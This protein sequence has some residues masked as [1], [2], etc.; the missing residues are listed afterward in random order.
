MAACD[1]SEEVPEG[2]YTARI[3]VFDP[4]GSGCSSANRMPDGL[5]CLQVIAP[6]LFE[7]TCVC[8]IGLEDRR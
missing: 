7:V 6:L 4:Q 3:L 1:D 8:R 2:N 5:H